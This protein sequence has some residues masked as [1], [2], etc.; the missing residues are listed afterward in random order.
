MGKPLQLVWNRFGDRRP[1]KAPSAAIGSRSVGDADLRPL[2]G[3]V[4]INDMN[5]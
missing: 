2:Q 1:P 5:G 4:L 3:F